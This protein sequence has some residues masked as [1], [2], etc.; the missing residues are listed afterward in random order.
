MRGDKS[1]ARS[2]KIESR[3]LQLFDLPREEGQRER[4]LLWQRESADI[5]PARGIKGAGFK[6]AAW[7]K[8]RVNM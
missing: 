2:L 1:A 5:P 6:D 3:L 4:E 7:A 8:N